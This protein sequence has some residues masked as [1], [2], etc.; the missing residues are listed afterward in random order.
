MTSPSRIEQ[1]RERV[2]RDWDD[3]VTIAGWRKWGAASAQMLAGV[4][5]AIVEAAGA[6]P[7]LSVLDIASGAGQPALMLAA[8]VAPSGHVMAT[9]LSA[10]MLAV[11]EENARRENLTNVRVQQAD[12]EALPFPDAAFDRVT[13]RFGAMFFLDPV[14]AMREC[15]RVLKPGGK[16]VFVVWGPPQQP[17][18]LPA[19]VLRKFA[20]IPE[21]EPDAPH[22]FR[23]AAPGSLSDVLCRGGFTQVQEEAL[24]V[25]AERVGTPETSWEEFRDMAAPFR[26]LIDGLPPARRAE[27]DAAVVSA[28]QPFSS[29]DRMKLFVRV[30]LVTG[31][32]L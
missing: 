2:R 10:G 14:H 1:Y 7:G 4:N 8:A 26:P 27:L 3:P 29:G 20:E 22:I 12:V 28:L 11:V 5:R 31:I 21:P 30:N 17:F 24:Q 19:A 23:Y 6:A 13:C 16:A 25:P 18:F 15:F 9:D 32:R